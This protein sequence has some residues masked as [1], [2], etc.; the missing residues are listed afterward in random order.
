MRNITRCGFAKLTVALAAVALF[1]AGATSC[2][3]EAGENEESGPTPA[4]NNEQQNQNQNQQ[5]DNQHAHSCDQV[6]CPADEVCEEGEC[7]DPC[8]EVS[9]PEGEIC[10]QGDC[11]LEADT[12][13]SCADPFELGE[14]EPGD[15]ETFEVDASGQ[16]NLLQ[17]S[18]ADGTDS[19]EAVFRVDVDGPS[20]V[21]FAVT[22]SEDV[23]ARVMEVRRDDCSDDAELHRFG[24][25]SLHGGDETE[26]IVDEDT[27]LFIVVQAD[28]GT[29][30]GAF[31]VE[32][33]V[34]EALCAPP[35]IEEG[36]TYCGAED[37]ELIACFVDEE[38][39]YECG[40]D[41]IDGRCAGDSCVNAIEV[42]SSITVEG[43][44]MNPA[45]T[46]NFQFEPFPD[47]SDISDL[48]GPNTDG[49]D[50]VFY[51]PDL[52]AGDEVVVDNHGSDHHME[53]NNLLGILDECDEEMPDCVA[54]V[55]PDDDGKMIWPVEEDGDYYAVVNLETP[56]QSGDFSY[57]VDIQ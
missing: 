37:R 2:S 7:V 18:C 8:E 20:K 36:G 46:S 17:T 48:T 27:E 32:A 35:V 12:G 41:C 11:E 39:T 47:C 19:S 14:I 28:D 13:Y 16:P 53:M 54:G 23:T 4:D 56:T 43:E 34:E 57:T 5:N 52:I 22:D 33:S 30:P 50:V 51:L 15:S 25:Q 31:T 38:K 6:D 26:L 3:P 55:R 9:C 24:C 45:Y 10:Y 21:N 29:T 42:N 44:I 40:H 1:A 49:Q